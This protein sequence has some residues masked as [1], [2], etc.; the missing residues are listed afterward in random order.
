MLRLALT[1]GLLALMGWQASGLRP[2]QINRGSKVASRWTTQRGSLR[3]Y[4]QE[5]SSGS[6][7]NTNSTD[8]SASSSYGSL[9]PSEA[10]GGMAPLQP[11]AYESNSNLEILEENA[12]TIAI[13]AA[14]L[15]EKWIDICVEQSRP[16]DMDKYALRTILP[17]LTR[18]DSVLELHNGDE[19]EVSDDVTFISEQ[20]LQKVW[21]QA[22]H[23]AMGKPMSSFTIDEALLLLPDKDA[24]DVMFTGVQEDSVAAEAAVALEKEDTEFYITDE[25]LQSIWNNR[26][27]V[28]WGM[29][30]KEGGKVEFDSKLAL[31]LL[32]TDEDEEIFALEE[33]KAVAAAESAEEDED[34]DEDHPVETAGLADYGLD[35]GTGVTGAEDSKAGNLGAYAMAEGAAVVMDTNADADADADAGHK[36]VKDWLDKKYRGKSNAFLRD[37]IRRLHAELDGNTYLRPAWKKDRHILT[38]DIDTQSF[39][40]DIMNSNL[41]MTT[42]IPANWN[43]PE[44]EEMSQTYLDCG[45]MA[46]PGEEETDYN[47]ITPVWKFLNLPFSP[48]GILRAM[49]ELSQERNS[50][51]FEALSSD[52]GIIVSDSEKSAAGLALATT[53]VGSASGSGSFAAVN[54]RGNVE[55]TQDTDSS[56][57]GDNRNHDALDVD[58]F[59]SQI[60]GAGGGGMDDEDFDEDEGVPREITSPLEPTETNPQLTRKPKW[61][62]PAAW[63]DDN[64]EFSDHVDFEVWSKYLWGGADADANAMQKEWYLADDSV[65]VDD[66][67]VA[68]SVKQLLEVTEDTLTDHTELVE[69]VDDLKMW[70]RMLGFKFSGGADGDE[71][72]I[73]PI[74]AYLTPDK[75]EGVTYSDELI[76]MKGRVTLAADL[77]PPAEL[78]ADDRFEHNEEFTTINKVGTIREQYDWKV[79]SRDSKDCEFDEA[80]IAKIGPVLDYVNHGA[81]LVSTRNNVLVFDYKGQMRHIVGIRAAMLELCKKVCPEIVDIRLETDRGSDKFDGAFPI[82]K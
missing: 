62:T 45:T 18:E 35:N 21:E 72:E 12:P 25:E 6:S 75:E 49:E 52:L 46:W 31:L 27:D 38:P 48:A 47:V 73:E 55:W 61:V 16:Q 22:S 82:T 34:E 80:I 32:D 57:G 51:D 1:I 69:A 53:P 76:E 37:Q 30:A 66:L 60:Q 2:I 36:H 78:F 9:L 19:E 14:T 24:D 17:L 11:E 43:D 29:P 20:E 67:V 40:G 28:P 15:N 7:I 13:D 71:D 56:L 63:A 4:S 58:K 3:L 42:R 64:P 26:G 33:A 59:F 50:G 65:W 70:R 23:T 39:M 44:L 68:N 81:E 77:A 41:Y 79:S 10:W 54:D 8:N 74:P 5:L